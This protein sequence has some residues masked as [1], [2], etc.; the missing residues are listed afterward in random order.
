MQYMDPLKVVCPVCCLQQLR[1]VKELRSLQ[2]VCTQ[3]GAS[4][5]DIGRGMLRHE[6]RIANQIQYVVEPLM[7]LEDQLGIPIPDD[8]SWD[9]I[10]TKADYVAAVI[11]YLAANAPEKAN[12]KMISRAFDQSLIRRG[13]LPPTSD[14]TPLF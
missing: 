1:S 7:D 3:C 14:S 11:S 4:L 5:A 8:A 13:S 2:A 10:R 9:S 6:E 12:P